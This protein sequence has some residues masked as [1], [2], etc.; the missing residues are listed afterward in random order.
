MKWRHGQRYEWC[1]GPGSV[2]QDYVGFVVHNV[3]SSSASV[4]IPLSTMS[5]LDSV[6]IQATKRDK[7]C[8]H[9]GKTKATAIQSETQLS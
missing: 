4:V 3:L 2:P 7:C 9:N 1:G 5:R 6:S 8:Q